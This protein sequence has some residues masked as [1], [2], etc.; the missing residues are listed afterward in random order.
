M[1]A[2]WIALGVGLVYLASDL[3]F[4]WM[5]LGALA[6]GRRSRPEMALTFDDGPDPETTP[7]LLSALEET[8]VK[9]TFFLTGEK[10]ERH[11]EL[12]RAIREAGHEIASHGRWHR[13]AILMAPWTEYR[14]IAYNPGGLSYY[15]PP[16][17][18]HSPFT[19]LLAGRLGRKVALWDVESKDWTGL[20]DE[21]VTKRLWHYVSGGSV[22]LLHDGPRAAALVKKLVPGLLARG[23]KPVPM[24][25]LEAKPLGFRAALARA[26]QG[27]DERFDRQRGV[28]RCRESWD[29][30]FRCERTVYKGPPLPGVRPGAKGLLLHFDSKRIAAFSPAR[31]FLAL[32]KDL[33]AIARRVEKDPEIA[34]IFAPTPLSEGARRLGFA[35]APLPFLDGLVAGLAARFFDWLYRDPR[36][37]RRHPGKL[38]LIYMTRQELLKRYLDAAP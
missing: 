14:Q 23:F 34:L 36:L 30:V 33:A 7:A 11:P 18:I 31:G 17:G 22:V 1:A 21:A 26:L 19:R 3:L 2:L 24:G 37:K 5:G 9:A 8:G 38:R 20:D 13:P 27:F 12:V 25:A 10:A 28:V 6:H 15:R 4:R 32:R 16:H 35:T 29:N